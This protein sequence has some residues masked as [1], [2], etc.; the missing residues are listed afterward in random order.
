[1]NGES[2]NY[3]ETLMA[4]WFAVVHY[5]TGLLPAVALPDATN[6]QAAPRHESK[7]ESCPRQSFR[8]CAASVAKV[9][10]HAAR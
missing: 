5:L 6:P 9:L 4:N 10:P 7:C 8:Y 3:V 2:T 1:M